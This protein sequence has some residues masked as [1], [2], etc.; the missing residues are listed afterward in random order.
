[1]SGAAVLLYVLWYIPNVYPEMPLWL[2]AALYA[3][4][5]LLLLWSWR[6]EKTAK[7][8]TASV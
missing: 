6:K 7:K 8:H 5:F 3:P 4:T 2:G 1:L